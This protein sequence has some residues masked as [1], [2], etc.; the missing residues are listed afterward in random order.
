MTARCAI[1][2]FD[3]FYRSENARLLHFFR[4]RV[5]WEAAPD[6]VQDAFTRVLRSGPFERIENP[7]AYLTRTARN[8]LIEQARRKMREQRV[9][10][11]LDEGRDA[12]VAPEQT[13]QIEVAELRRIYRRALRAMPRRTRRI[14]LMHRLRNMTY[15][16]IAEQLGLSDQ[17]VEYHMMRALAGCR[18]AVAALE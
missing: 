14:F 1:A 8:L 9:F 5:G 18:K 3:A 17:G 13:W 2:S 4:K 16:E 10:F 6:L 12:S 15:R 11:P 7:P